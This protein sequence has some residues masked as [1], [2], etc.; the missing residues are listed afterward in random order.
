ML[1]LHLK[2]N[3][4]DNNLTTKM[5]QYRRK[6]HL[7]CKHALFCQVPLNPQPIH[8]ASEEC[9]WGHCWKTYDEEH[10]FHQLDVE[11]TII[12]PSVFDPIEDCSMVMVLSTQEDHTPF[13]MASGCEVGA[14]SKPPLQ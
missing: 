4:K 9:C 7:I 14:V 3:H 11:A 1:L 13:K 2:M 10:G 12:L 6:E 5:D 8:L